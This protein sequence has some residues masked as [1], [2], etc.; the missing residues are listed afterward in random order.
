MIINGWYERG[1]LGAPSI[2]GNEERL[3][4]KSTRNFSIK[5]QQRD[6]PRWKQEAYSNQFWTL[7]TGKLVP[8]IRR[9]PL[10]WSKL[11][12]CGKTKIQVGVHIK[13]VRVFLECDYQTSLTSSAVAVSLRW[14]VDEG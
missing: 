11:L 13:Y 12:Q 14:E 7:L 5:Y 4:S 3:L 8:F 10:P 1:K 2:E 9:R 6:P